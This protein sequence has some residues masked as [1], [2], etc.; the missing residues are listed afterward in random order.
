MLFTTFLFSLVLDMLSITYP[1][2][3]VC[4]N[5]K[6]GKYDHDVSSRLVVAVIFLELK[7]A[8]G[9]EDHEA[10]EHAHGTSHEGLS[11]T[12][13]LDDVQSTEGAAEVYGTEDGRGDETVADADG[14]E[15]GCAVVE[16]WSG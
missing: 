2:S 4:Q 7:V 16:D 10:D 15:D 13:V 3:G 1:S 6:T 8:D 9:G 5:K 12:K 11:T 14:L